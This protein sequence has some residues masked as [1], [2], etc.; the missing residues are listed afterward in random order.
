MI[1]LPQ[2]TQSVAK[3]ILKIYSWR[4]LAFLAVNIFLRLQSIYHAANAFFH[5]VNI[6]IEQ[7][8][9]LTTT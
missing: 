4:F 6:K 8:A 7:K 3:F 5:P 1:L 9:Q 2:R